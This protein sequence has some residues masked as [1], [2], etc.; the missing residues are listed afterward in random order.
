MPEESMTNGGFLMVKRKGLMNAEKLDQKLAGID[1]GAV[2]RHLRALPAPCYE[3]TL[4]RIAFPDME[5]ASASPLDLYRNHFA[6]F[7]LLYRLQEEFYQEGVYLH[8]HFMRIFLAEYPVSGKCRYY[9]DDTGQFCGADCA[10]EN[11]YCPFHRNSVG[12]S[13]VEALSIK[14][15]YL[16]RD[17]FDRLDEKTAEAFLQGAWDLLTRY[18]EYEKSL[19]VLGIIGAPDLRTVKRNFR[20]LAMEHHPDR[21]AESHRRFNEINRAYRLLL[22]VIPG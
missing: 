11:N 13:A 15:F 17:N 16:D 4:L 21:G 1:L 8:V 6:L 10:G 20:R 9:I 18:G 2:V 22:R 14:Y 5:I 19:S 12:E 7:H 3:S